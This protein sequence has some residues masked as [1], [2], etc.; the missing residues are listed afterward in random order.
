MLPPAWMLQRA[1]NQ[2]AVWQHR[3]MPLAHGVDHY[4]NFPVA[5]VLC[6]RRWRSAVIAVYH[7]ARTADDLADEGDAPAPQRLAD[8]AR[9]RAA[10]H[11]LW[12]EAPLPSVPA[13]WQPMLAALDRARVRHALPRQPLDDLLSAFE[14]DVRMTAAGNRYRDDA[15]LLDYC[16]RSANP[17]GRLLLHLAGLND[18]AAL[19]ESD[20]ICTA[21]QLINFWQDLGQD[22]ARGR[23][24]LTDAALRAH[25]LSPRV[26]L[27]RWTDAELAPIVLEGCRQARGLMARGWAL[28][29]RLGGRF[30]WELRLVMQGGLRI[31]ERIEALG[32]RT[33]TQRPRLSAW[34]APVL[35]AR[36]IR[37]RR[38]VADPSTPAP[39]SVFLEP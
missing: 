12:V 14:Q 4:E 9:L 18:E 10:L 28:P 11:A 23:S 35:V 15:D 34:D 24:Y 19:R 20:A 6:P 21:L 39:A 1:K 5:S 16:R 3:G 37:H 17:I 13:A 22:L 31:V 30:G 25:G 33:C 27:A 32:G 8:L 36:A 26:E 29:T 7:F 2:S 38:P